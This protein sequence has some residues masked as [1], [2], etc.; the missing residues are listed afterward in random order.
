[1]DPRKIR[2]IV[3]WPAPTN[4]SKVRIFMGLAS[5]YRKFVANFSNIAHPITSLQRK[6]K[7]FVWSD[8]CEEAF[9]LLKEHLTSAPV[10]AVPNPSKEFV[11]CT[12]ASV[13]GL[14]AILMPDGRVIA[15]ESRKLKDHEINYPTHDLELAAVMHALTKW[16]NFLLGQNFELR[17]D[18]RSLQYIFI[19]PNLN[20]RKHRWMEFLCE[21]N[22]EVK[23]I[24]GKENK[25]ADALSR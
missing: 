24:Q 7:K 8:K 5:Y 13:D 10:L 17:T 6:G 15:Y 4:V 1:M 25:V 18:H 19:Q 21:Y 11:V 16:Q 2:A 23:Y 22:F 20:A 12:D 14:G 3:E 9:Q